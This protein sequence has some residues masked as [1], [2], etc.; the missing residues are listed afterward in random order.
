M[1]NSEF[2]RNSQSVLT[3]TIVNRGWGERVAALLAGNGCRFHLLTH[4]TGTADT[5]LLDYLGLGETDKDLVL[6]ILPRDV[7][8]ETLLLLERRIELHKSGHGIAFTIPIGSILSVNAVN[9]PQNPLQGKKEEN[10]VPQNEYDLIVICSNKGYTDDIMD[11][12]RSA[13]AKGGTALHARRVGVQEAESF[14][15]IT[16]QPEK[17]V[18]LILT[19]HAKKESVM[20]AVM[21]HPGLQA[22]TRAVVFSLPV[23]DVAGLAT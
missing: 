4:A 7:A 15:G 9:D 13:N 17:E 14:F 22:Q 2:C 16:I 8:K 10:E 12:A 21:E 3:V 1:M 20:R 23:G 18:I 19:E 6:S 5:K 11:A